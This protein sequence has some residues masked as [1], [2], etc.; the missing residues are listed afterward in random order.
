MDLYNPSHRRRRVEEIGYKR[1]IDPR[2]GFESFL[3]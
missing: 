1:R 2:I 3:I